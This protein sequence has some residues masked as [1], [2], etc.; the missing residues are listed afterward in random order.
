M[1]T[2]VRRLADARAVLAATANDPYARNTVRPDV[3]TVHGWQLGDAVAWLGMDAEERIP[4]MSVLGPAADATELV[5]RVHREV[6]AG[7]PLTAEAGAAPRLEA[8]LGFSPRYH[9]EFSTISEPPEPV[10]DVE[11]VVLL[12]AG[13]D[14]IRD[15][16][17]VTSTYASALPGDPAINRW[18]V[19]E[20]AGRLVACGA[21]TSGAAGVGHM[22]SVAVH[23]DARGRGLGTAVV[24]WLTRDLLLGSCDVVVVGV[25]MT[26]TAARR[27][28]HQLGF[29]HRHEFR[30]GPMDGA[31]P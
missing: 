12:V 21:D 25:L 23:P 11:V 20:E 14:R 27:L 9:W 10:E 1:S 4:Y 2:A 18:V 24:A 7:V 16:L 3:V 29:T 6:P 26:D 30:S 5:T 28:Y 17:Q 31:G 15:L 22:G 13:S 8:E 19:V